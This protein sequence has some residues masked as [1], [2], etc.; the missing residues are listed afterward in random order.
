[1]QL[2]LFFYTTSVFSQNYGTAGYLNLHHSV[3]LSSLESSSQ[4]NPAAMILDTSNYILL[5]SKPSRFGISEL[6]PFMI[7]AAFSLDSS[8]VLGVNLYG[9]G[10]ELYSEV[11]GELRF[12]NKINDIVSVGASIELNRL[13]IKNYENISFATINIGAVINLSESLKAGF[14]LRNLLRNNAGQ[15]DKT[16]YQES[17]AGL[18]YRINSEIFIDADIAVIINSVSSYG[19]A[20]KYIPHDSFALRTAFKT[21]PNILE[22]AAMLNIYSDI[23]FSAGIEY[24]EVFGISPELTVKFIM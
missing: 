13:M 24:N 5:G 16:T 8:R 2:I 11:S 12:A 14:A 21:N 10:G 18:S 19:F 20:V 6:N 17:V 7:A 9:L 4:I 3:G 15:T 22:I 23:Y 1:M